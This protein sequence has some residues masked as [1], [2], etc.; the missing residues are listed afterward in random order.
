MRPMSINCRYGQCDKEPAKPSRGILPADCSLDESLLCSGGGS[1][2][3]RHIARGGMASGHTPTA[4]S[5]HSVPRHVKMVTKRHRA[6]RLGNRIPIR[7]H[8]IRTHPRMRPSKPPSPHLTRRERH[9]LGFTAVF[10]CARFGDAA[11]S[12]ASGGVAKD[13]GDAEVSP[14]RGHHH[15]QGRHGTKRA[16][17]AHRHL[18]S[19]FARASLRANRGPLHNTR[20]CVR[21]SS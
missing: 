17:F 2:R 8:R 5:H 18:R 19:L 14:I 20:T 7:K 1:P 4:P 3:R 11:F 16:S 10:H 13:G 15:A 6:R 21:L 12:C 9:R